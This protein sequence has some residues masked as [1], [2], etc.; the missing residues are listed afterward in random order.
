MRKG[1]QLPQFTAPKEF[2][3]HIKGKG[4]T[5]R[6][7]KLSELKDGAVSW[8]RKDRHWREEIYTETEL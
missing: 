5:R 6:S 1:L 2:P 8:L 7:G 4:G 3:G